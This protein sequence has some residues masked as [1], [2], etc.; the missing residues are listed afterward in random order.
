MSLA[1][2]E[3]EGN[4][5][6]DVRYLPRRRF[7]SVPTCLSTLRT[8]D[9]RSSRTRLVNVLGVSDHVHVQ[10]PI[11]MQ[12]VDDVSRRDADGGDE[13]LRPASDDD[14]DQFV[15][16][17][18]GVVKLVGAGAVREQRHMSQHGT[19]ASGMTGNT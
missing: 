11:G 5:D 12:L 15:E 18:F 16:R 1:C 17:A 8:D 6:V 2:V 3:G 7:P 13:E 4:L 19:A 14:V 9:V 10:D